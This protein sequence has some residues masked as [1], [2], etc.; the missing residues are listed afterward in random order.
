[1][2]DYLGRDR[3]SEERGDGLDPNARNQLIRE[4]IEDDQAIVI[5]DGL[6]ELNETNRIVSRSSSRSRS[7]SWPMQDPKGMRETMTCLMKG[8]AIRSL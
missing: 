8:A 7:L 3:E 2:I 4:R 6:D 5:L 1:M